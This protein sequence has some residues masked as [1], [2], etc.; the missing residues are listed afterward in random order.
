MNPTKANSKTQ[1]S[2][3]RNAHDITPFFISSTHCEHYWLPLGGC[4][5][6]PITTPDQYGREK[7][8]SQHGIAEFSRSI[9]L[10]G[11]DG[12]GHVWFGINC[13]LFREK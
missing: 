4:K 11:G 8:E 9:G 1:Q 7:R 13:S 12:S 3:I 5:M 2:E 10:F 6:H